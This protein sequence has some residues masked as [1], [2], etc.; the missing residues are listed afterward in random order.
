MTSLG[1]LRMNLPGTFVEKYVKIVIIYWIF[2]F[3]LM[4]SI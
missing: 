1:I 2:N 3:M 4:N